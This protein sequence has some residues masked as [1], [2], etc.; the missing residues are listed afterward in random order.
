MPKQAPYGAWE[1]PIEAAALARAGKRLGQVAL[2]GRDV[3]WVE[4]RPDEGGRSVL[5]RA[6]P[7]GGGSALT[8]AP[9]DVR[10]R[11]HE[12]G[13]G[14]YAVG[15]SA[16]YFSHDVDGRVYA[17]TENEGTPRPLT[18][19]GP[20]RYADL[21]VDAP[22]SRL[23]AVRERE[24][25]GAEP[26]NELVTIDTRTGVTATVAAG[27][28]FFASPRL[29]PRGTEIAWLTW[30]HPRMPWDGTEL[31]L[32]QLD[33]E[34]NP[35]EP[36]RVAGGEDESVFQPEWSPDGTLYFVSDRSGWW[37]LY[38]L[39]NGDVAKGG[40]AC[41]LE[42]EAEYGLAQWVFGQSTYAFV[43]DNEIVAARRGGG[44]WQLVRVFVDTGVRKTIDLPFSEI[45]SV[46]ASAGALAF[47]AGSSDRPAAVV[48][49]S[50]GAHGVL[51]EARVLARS[52]DY[53]VPDG[54]VS[55][56]EPFEYESAGGEI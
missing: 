26:A 53:E 11:V 20:W 10:T 40:I 50:S 28:D 17:V 19:E 36:Q 54:F 34:G 5:M 52:S 55:A 42:D 41:V 8:P 44:G 7:G 35:G 21:S 32:S 9:F 49:M 33:P 13:G 24:V 38:R 46:R 30:D 2:A 51:G 48:S 1:S 37:N 18:A 12:Y 25:E 47:I 15:A 39:D 27:H 14:A 43:S 29:S 56:P 22:R 23:Y 31:W 45:S 4:G 6:R 3:Y 16:L